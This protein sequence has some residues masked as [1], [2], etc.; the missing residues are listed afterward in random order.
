MLGYGTTQ[1]RVKYECG[2]GD[3]KPTSLFQTWRDYGVCIQESKLFLITKGRIVIRVNGIETE[4]REGEIVLIP[5]GIKHDYYLRE[6]E[7]AEKYWFHFSLSDRRRSYFDSISL[8]L[9]IKADESLAPLFIKVC[10]HSN[11]N[12]SSLSQLSAILS[13]VEYFLSNS[14]IVPV[15]KEP[16]ETEKIMHYINLNF[17]DELSLAK[18]AALVHLSPNYLVRKFHKRTGFS[19]MQYLFAARINH[20]KTLLATTDLSISSVMESV[21]FYD[22]AHFSK[23]FKSATGYSPRAYRAISKRS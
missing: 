5:A 14:K 22:A 9:K 10:S 8:P 19:P 3:G 1:L 18:L 13:I 21:G 23:Q 20:A 17:A 6:G 7:T 16:D 12:L 4:C 15:V 2:P 11:D